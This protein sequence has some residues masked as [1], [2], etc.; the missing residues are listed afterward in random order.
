MEGKTK[1][2]VIYAD[3]P[4]NYSNW[5]RGSAINHYDCMTDDEIRLLPV[6]N[7]AKDETVLI[8]AATWPFLPTAITVI[9]AW[10][11]KYVTGFPFV[12]TLR[13][14]G[15]DVHGELVATPA[16]GTG[17]W[18]RGCSGT[19][20][21]AR[22]PKA[23]P[24]QKH[25]MGI[26]GRRLEHSRKPE[27]IYE[28]CES[29]PGPYLELFA[30]RERPGW[31]V[32]GDG[33]E[34]DIDIF[35]GTRDKDGTIDEILLYTIK[36]M[37]EVWSDSRNYRWRLGDL[38]NEMQA[39]G[40]TAMDSYRMGAEVMGKS[41]RWAVELASVSKEFGAEYRDDSIEWNEYRATYIEKRPGVFDEIR[42]ANT[43]R[44][45]EHDATS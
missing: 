35:S 13:E 23:R 22:G 10:G 24:P 29:I 34:C 15:V 37:R 25:W 1:Y 32:W 33:V 26:I 9:D 16:W 45:T 6:Q 21:I 43:P 31:N 38:M 39:L 44:N 18:S 41:V 42:D 40:M 14:P 30:R 5:G 2:G 36:T 8:L 20:L 4:W 17:I 11:F 28:Y 27:S 3:P 12:K 7:W 19:F